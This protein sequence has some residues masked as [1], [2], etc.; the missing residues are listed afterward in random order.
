M[1]IREVKEGVQEVDAN[2]EI[3]FTIDVSN[4]G[5]AAGALSSLSTVAT[6][7]SDG[8]VVTSTVLSGSTTASA[9]V[10]TLPTLKSLTEGEQYRL[11]VRF[12]KDGNKLECEL[13][14]SCPD[15]V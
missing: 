7:L 14:V 4:V 10:I 13:F 8:T 6:K 15:Q 2:E 12:T 1:G 9:Q 11:D 3:V 5:S